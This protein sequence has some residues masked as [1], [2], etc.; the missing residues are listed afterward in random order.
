MVR[1]GQPGIQNYFGGQKG[2]GGQPEAEKRSDDDSRKGRFGWCEFE[3]N[4]IPYIFRSPGQEKYTSVRMVERKLLDKFLRILPSELY[5]NSC[6]CI[7]SYYIT[8]VESKLLNEINLKHTDCHFGKEAFTSKDMVVKLSDGKE[9][10]R[11]LD[12]CYKKLVLKK[13]N[14]T[15]RC[16][17]FRINGESVVP[18]TMKEGVK[19]VPLFYF[20]GET[21]HLELR[22][23]K[24]DGWDLAYL[25]FCCKVQGVRDELF[26]DEICRVVALDEIRG[27]FPAGTTFE[28]YWPA[29]GSIE[30]VNSAQRVSAG[31]WT[32]KPA[33]PAAAPTPSQ[34]QANG[35]SN[36]AATNSAGGRQRPS[37]AINSS[38]HPHASQASSAVH[39]VAGGDGGSLPSPASPATAAE[40]SCRPTGT[41]AAAAAQ[42]LQQQQ[43]QQQLQQQQQQ[44][45]RAAAAAAQQQDKA[46]PGKMTQVKEFPYER[47]STQAPY[48]LQ[49]ALIDQ[50]IVPCINVRPFVF[51]DLMMTLP[52]FVT[53]FYPELSIEKA[54]N[55][56]QD[57]LKVVLYK[58]NSGH[59]EVLRNEKKCN[60]YDP[61]PLVLVKDIMNYMP[62]MKYM[63]NSMATTGGSAAG[64]PSDP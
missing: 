56:L 36:A 47:N 25:K 13:S 42:Q 37:A 21:D 11:F 60:R 61:V 22:S 6:Y 63:F 51:R 2:S 28:D 4:H 43:R 35:T 18:Y 24:V 57:I 26:A 44:Q 39:A 3:K 29:K 45:Q 38:A 16:G 53:H 9:F 49:K 30:P 1:P 31:N 7:K 15:D 33:Q 64:A 46:F 59:Q 23:D 19:Y 41:T 20:E 8:D 32:Q 54:R 62:Q 5:N 52:D 14:A 40:S 27:H 58:G 55:M 12:L 34:Q 10:Y 48:K 50:K 17:F